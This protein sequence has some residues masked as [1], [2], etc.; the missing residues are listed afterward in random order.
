MKIAFDIFARLLF[1]TRGFERERD[2]ILRRDEALEREVRLGPTLAT[3]RRR[4]YHLQP[5]FGFGT[6]PR[7]LVFNLRETRSI[8]AQLLLQPGRV[9]AL[10]V[11]RA[12]KT[13][14]DEQ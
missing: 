13:P 10:Y 6:T 12:I 8:R 5:R 14:F 1:Q 9:R 2:V 4:L 11:R 7:A 3:A